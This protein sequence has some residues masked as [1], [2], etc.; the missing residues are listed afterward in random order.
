MNTF[1]LNPCTIAFSRRVLRTA[2]Q[3]LWSEAAC[4][5]KQTKVLAPR[6]E[7]V[8]HVVI[9]LVDWSVMAM[10]LRQPIDVRGP[11]TVIG[12]TAA[13]QIH[14]LVPSPITDPQSGHARVGCLINR[15]SCFMSMITI[16]KTLGLCMYIYLPS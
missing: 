9:L 5:E 16:F 10:F 2:R 6:S 4:R 13:M 1:G 14:K 8:R 15:M 3:T 11:M 7:N 12:S